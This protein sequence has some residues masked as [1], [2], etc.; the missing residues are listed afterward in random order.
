TEACHRAIEKYKESIPLW[1]AAKDKA[2]EAT[3]HYIIAGVYIFLGDKQNSFDFSKRA[4]PLAEEAAKD[5]DEEK[6]AIGIKTEVYALFQI[7]QA[8]SEFD[9]KK[10]ALEFF[11]RA[12][13]LARA[14]GDRPRE[15]DVL[16]NIGKTLVFMGDYQKALGV[17]TQGRRIAAELGDRQKEAGLVN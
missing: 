10:K 7:G 8:Y 16:Y 2:W 1:Q 11:D 4:L 15:S 17:T 12:L 6:R 14:T 13:S 9:D 3:T 5:P